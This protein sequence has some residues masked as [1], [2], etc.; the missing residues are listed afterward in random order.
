ML[1]AFRQTYRSHHLV[2]LQQL[3]TLMDPQLRSQRLYPV[4]R[5]PNEMQLVYPMG[6]HR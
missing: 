1:M 4:F 3:H 2:R 5:G 6:T